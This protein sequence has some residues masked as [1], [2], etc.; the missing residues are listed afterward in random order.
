MKAK[1]K[2]NHTL[3]IV[4][5]SLLMLN[6]SCT[7]ELDDLE[8]ATFPV[9]SE[10]FL[11]GF[12][13][14][15]QYAAFGN[16][17]VDAFEV[18][19]DVTYKGEASMRF[20]VPDAGDPSGGYAGG[21]FIDP[22][23]RDLSQFDVLS[24][25]ARAT[26]NATINEI[27]FGSETTLVNF[28]GAK[29]NTNWQKFYIPI[30]DPAVL[31]QEQGMLWYAEPPEN[32]LGYTFWLDEVQF[33][34][35]GK[36]ARPRPIIFDGTDVARTAE[37]GDKINPSG[38]FITYNLPNGVDQTIAIGTGYFNFSSSNTSVA[39]INNLGEVTV[40]S[41]GEAVITAK[42]G[43]T[44]AV[45]SLTITSTGEPILP[46]E[47]A[48]M[49]TVSPDSVISMFSNVYNDVEVDTWNPFWEFSTTE[50]ADVKI[51]EDDVKRYNNLN[52]VGIL[53]EGNKIDA[54]EMT[55]FHMDIWTPDATA[56][57][58]EFKVLLVDFGADGNFGGGDDSSHE[59]TFTSPTLVSESWVSLDIPL[60]DFAGLVNRN[61]I[62]Q[63]VLSGDLPNLF[64]DNVYYY[65]SGSSG[66]VEPTTAAPTPSAEANNVISLFSN[67]YD[68]V[69][70]DT[71]S[72]E[73]DQAGVAD[74]QV[75]GDDVKLYTGLAFAGVEFLSQ[76]IDASAM[77][78][79]H[80]DI[81][82]ADPTAAPAVFKIKLVDF[83][84]DNA[85]DGGDDTEH[86]IILDA[87]TNPA[88]A[89]ESWV[90]IDIPFSDFTGLTNRS[91]LAQM[92]ISGDPNTVYV[93]NVYL[94][95]GEGMTGGDEPTVAAPTPI[96]NEANVISLFSDAYTDVT[97]DTWQTEW[98]NVGSYED[99][100][101][102]GNPTKKYSDLTFV[103]I[104]TVANQLDASEMTHFHIDVWSADFTTFG[105]NL[106][107]FGADGAFDGGDDTN[108]ELLFEAPMQGGWISYDIPLSD[109]T[110][111]TTKSNLA[112][113]ILVGRPEGMNTIYVD[114]IYFYKEDGV[115]PMEPQE[116]APT[117]TQDETNVI[118]LFSDAYMDVTVDTWQTEWSNV[119]S[120]EDVMI[121]GNPTKKY[122]ELTFVG[123][124]TV[125][126]QLNASEMTHFH[127]DVWSAD[128]TTF[129]INLVDFGA[130]GAFDGGD[131]TNHELLFEA[132][133]QGGWISY[134]IPLSDF[135]GLTTK[136]NL[137][138]YILVGRPEGAN[139]IY[140]DNIYFYKEE[141]EIPMAPQEAAP[142]PTLDAA[143]VISIFSDAY[144]DV[145]VDTWRT[146]WSNGNFEDVTI[147]GNPTKKYFDLTFAG[148]ET[149]ANQLDIS[150][151]TH[152][153][154]DV[155]SPDF[156]AFGIN[157]VDFG[158][159]GAFDG[160]DDA[161]HELL[162]ETP[163]R[164]TWIQY[165]IPLSDFTGLITKSNLAQYILVGRPE[166]AS[167]IFVDNIYFH[168]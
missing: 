29:L 10:V 14:G 133:M 131:D 109:F 90:S 20:G 37:T 31:T 126:N 136:S 137:A 39:T 80:M 143:D 5:V 24:F 51:G 8:P 75:A 40:L 41:E 33:E 62:A 150:E 113:Y 34:N 110:G 158:P 155:W 138:Q 166:G 91:N 46:S 58:A 159:D 49:P 16:S 38:L 111:L 74:V 70:I 67:A 87:T 101:I 6:W 145:S 156:T 142:A 107:D 76:T 53:T 15:L 98:S 139:T 144:T 117:P 56:P 149:V 163:T 162:F 152:F 66:R 54:S 4:I 85:F 78:R 18:D 119:G 135:T 130:D 43:E 48:P 68:D 3:S 59:L 69:P 115:T 124:E 22:T 168:K 112:Q 72:A 108:H 161:N 83:G 164:G 77:D 114:N 21:E 151:M 127:V 71:W 1:I 95:A 157:L 23:G 122:S 12:P 45:G 134:D 7:R 88:L 47:P 19:M 30:P 120:Y 103:G 121:A 42:V 28:T 44:D 92:I 167:T 27:G 132:P 61:N 123:I 82:T 65:N 93:D 63:L 11:D 147:A 2:S 32:D 97:V 50:V 160:G 60:V 153:H 154:I 165:D 104:E 52:F 84:P 73:W 55:H 140:V 105:I 25:W 79:F 13:A 148:I 116:A 146:D 141:G 26:T 17:K 125:A 106:V 100:L 9:N 129:G 35:T 81:W 99:V 96:Q 102:T 89:T 64:V 118:S 36:L 57:P 128:F 94:Y 86:E